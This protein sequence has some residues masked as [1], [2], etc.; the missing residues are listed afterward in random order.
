MAILQ[1]CIWI[2]FD[3]FQDQKQSDDNGQEANQGRE[4]LSNEAS[5][6]EY[7]TDERTLSD[8]LFNLDK[9]DMMDRIFLGEDHSQD[10]GRILTL[11]VPFHVIIILN[12]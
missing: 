1:L 2:C 6:G 3:I 12:V 10:L 5:S 8:M 9:I 7:M 11:E 4:L